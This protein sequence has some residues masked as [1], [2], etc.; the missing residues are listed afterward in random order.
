MSASSAA[1][2]AVPSL[3][4]IGAGRVGQTLAHLLHRHGL[5]TM[6]SIWCRQPSHAH[7]AA[8]FI[9]L[10][11]PC[12]QWNEL[13]ESEIWLLGVPDSAIAPTAHALALHAQQQQ[14]KPSMA[15]HCSGYCASD[16]LQSLRALGWSV[17]SVH[18]AL[19]FANPQESVRQFANT[20]CGIEG[21]TSLASWLQHA[22][23]GIGGQ[24]FALRADTKALYHA[25]AVFCSNFTIALQD[26][27]QQAW[28]Q[29]GLPP[30]VALALNRQLLE[31]SVRNALNLG[32]A[33]AITGP[34]A[35][36][37]AQV[38]QDQYACVAQW[39]SAAG[40]IYKLMSNAAYR[41]ASQRNALHDNTPSLLDRTSPPA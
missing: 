37:D 21:D 9:G 26:I 20:L 36:G 7:A 19:N 18:P 40:D 15:F 11:Q 25:A 38:V 3:S 22:M 1:A 33:A 12:T 32:P 35:R 10:G 6:T 13:Q 41:L 34:A 24:A 2:P 23:T 27:A 30:D 29:A 4:V 5:A 14:W 17:A 39:S 16:Q 31:V 8:D 28:R